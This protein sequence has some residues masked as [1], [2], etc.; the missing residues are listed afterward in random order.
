MTAHR[1]QMR[2][3]RR[4]YLAEGT[5]AEESEASSGVCP[6]ELPLLLMLV[7]GGGS[8]FEVTAARRGC[9]RSAQFDEH[10]A[11][12]H[13]LSPPPW[14]PPITGF[15][16]SQSHSPPRRPGGGSES[17]AGMIGGIGLL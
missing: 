15:T 13:S 17:P 3:R 2:R 9:E 8:P 12:E 14:L 16:T 11:L 10:A 7:V 1:P 4:S 5:A 6:I